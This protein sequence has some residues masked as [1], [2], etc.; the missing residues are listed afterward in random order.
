M[1]ETFE[2]VEERHGGKSIPVKHFYKRQ[3][4]GA[5]G[6]WK[7]IYYARFVDWQGKRRMFP[8]GDSLA[9][10]RDKLGE[11]RTLNKGRYDFGKEKRERAKAKITAMTLAEW[12]DRYLDLVKT[13]ASY[14]TK[15]AQSIPLKRLLG[16][17]PLS[18]INR[19]RV[20]EYK[21]RRLSET[22][23]RH[24]EAVEGAQIKGATVNRE[25]S[26]LIT[27][28]NLA[29]DDGLCEGAPKI[30]KERE[31]PRERILTQA[32]YKAIVGASPRW[33]QRVVIA[34]NEAAIDRGV[35]L[36]LTWDCVQ[37]GLIKVKGGRA[38]TGATQIVGISPPLDDVLA[39]LRADYRRIPNTD[40]RVFTEGGKPITK[41]TLRR[42]FDKA[43]SD[44]KVEDFQLRDFRHC[45]RTQWAAAGL[46]Y[47]VAETAMGHKL[48]GMHGRYTNLSDD[49]IRVAFREM[50]EKMATR[51]QQGNQSTA[52]VN[53]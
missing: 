25:V 49:Q 42:A 16:D 6:Q 24:G 18:E 28:L 14:E 8:L 27:A 53:Q 22:I 15:R 48:P 3:Y 32:E 31:I 2:R 35:L 11:L 21:N 45:A 52:G 1:D 9:D 34:A 7:T 50:F 20:M 13:T 5:K 44:A 46:S 19:V 36:K 47:E 39:E 10:A 4:Q 23:I 51:W 41:D 12:L 17:L 40:R 37:D 38:K 33:L 26:C 30:K 43:M 29:A